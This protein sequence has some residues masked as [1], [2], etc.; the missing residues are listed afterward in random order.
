MEVIP[1]FANVD[2]F[3]VVRLMSAAKVTLARLV[4]PLK[5]ESP[6]L[7]TVFG[8]VIEVM[9]VMPWNELLPILVI[10]VFR[11]RL[12]IRVMFSNALA[13]TCVASV[14]VM[15]VKLVGT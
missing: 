9:P 4:L 10:P 8:M 5:A 1:V 2:E 7:V 3:I 15:V 6:I 12:V 14:I 13:L 11:I